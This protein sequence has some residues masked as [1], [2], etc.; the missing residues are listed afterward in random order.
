MNLYLMQ[1]GRPVAIEEDP[2]RPLSNQGNDEVKKVAEFLKKRGIRADKILH[3]GKMRARQTAEIIALRLTPGKE[4]LERN[5]ISPMDDITSFADE[6]K[7]C[8]ND[9]MVV[10]HLPYL[11]R[12]TSLLLIDS[13]SPFLIA[14]QQGG[15][16]CLSRDNDLVW[17]IRWMLVPEI[18]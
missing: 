16:L 15:V 12:L 4:P 5:D 1:H 13:E 3:S 6:I 9:L 2:E 11:A 17:T 14:F 8:D 7:E 18:I 10:G